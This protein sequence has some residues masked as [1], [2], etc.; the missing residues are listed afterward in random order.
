MDRRDC[1]LTGAD[2][3]FL[4]AA[5]APDVTGK[6]RLKQIVEHFLHYERRNVFGLGSG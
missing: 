2:V 1:R 6:A 3:D 4:I 5:A